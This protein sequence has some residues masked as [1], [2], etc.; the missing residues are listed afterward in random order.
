MSSLRIG[1]GIVWIVLVFVT[2]HAIQKQGIDGANIFIA[3]FSHPWR[4][5]FNSDFSAHL[6]L[7][8]IWIIYREPRLWV[9]IVCAVISVFCGGAFSL[10]YIVIA[11]FRAAGDARKLLLGK[12][13]GYSQ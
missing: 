11:T 9:G 5:Q 10:A 7:M 8:A 4:A 6:L 13:A 2:A 3:D 1:I 12:H